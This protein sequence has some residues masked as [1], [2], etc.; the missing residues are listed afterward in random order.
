MSGSQLV[1]IHRDYRNS[2]FAGFLYGD[3]LLLR[4]DDEDCIGKLAHRFN[5]A[6]S[7]FEFGFFPLS[8]NISFLVNAST[9]FGSF[10]ISS[11]LRN[12]RCFGGSSKN[13][14]GCRQANDYGR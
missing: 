10:S 4:V 3:L 12:A 9:I 1:S 13:L 8:P 5:A 7:L 11:S 14:S 2:Q 6:K